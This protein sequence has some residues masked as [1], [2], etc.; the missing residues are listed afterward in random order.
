MS[1]VSLKLSEISRQV[2]VEGL[3][4][5]LA[6]RDID[7]EE[8]TQRV[9]ALSRDL[10]HA[11]GLFDQ[12]RLGRIYLGALLHDVG[13]IGIP[14]AILQKKGRLTQQ[15]R[16][17]IQ[18]HPTY[19]FD[20]FRAHPDL[21]PLMDIAYCHHE[22]WDGTGYPRRLKGDQIPLEARLFAVVDVWDALTSKRHYRPAWTE[23]KAYRYIVQQSGRQFDPYIVGEFQKRYFDSGSFCRQNPAYEAIA[24]ENMLPLFA[25]PAV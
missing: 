2:Y 14:D 20:L 19:A 8:H 4:R 13:K 21:Y 9:A 24:R 23:E 1:I 3:V 16:I 6:L 11:T 18:K 15:E 12:V 5:L 7:T 22:K 25:Y 17:I 10:A